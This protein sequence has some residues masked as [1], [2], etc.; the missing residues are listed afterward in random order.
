MAVSPI[1]IL[2]ARA[3]ARAIL[4]DAGIFADFVEVTAPLL[5]YADEVGLFDDLGP[6]L[7]VSIITDPFKGGAV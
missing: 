6:D 2:R 5:D 4:L 1:L 7:V 3:E